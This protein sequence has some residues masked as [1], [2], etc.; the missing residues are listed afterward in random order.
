MLAPRGSEGKVYR[1][2][3]GRSAARISA[4]SATR[5]GRHPRKQGRGAAFK[6]R[7]R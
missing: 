2:A 1:K 5:P 4:N 3:S 6:A 7:L